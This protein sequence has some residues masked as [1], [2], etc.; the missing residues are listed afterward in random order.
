[1]SE[2]LTQQEIDALLRM[3]QGSGE[4]KA[5]EAITS[6]ESDVLGEVGNIGMGT[7]ATTLSVLINKKV[8]I[9]TPQVDVIKMKDLSKEC[10][11]PCVAVEIN[12]TQGLEGTNLLI[13][14]RHDV[15]VI[16]DLMMGGSGEVD[17]NDDELTD[18]H[19]SAI[20]EVMNQMMGSSSTSLSS[21]LGNQINISPP[22]PTPID[23]ADEKPIGYYE[24]DKPVVL[25]SFKMDIED[26]IHSKIMQ[27]MSID[28][29]KD[30][31]AKL[32]DMTIGSPEPID[33][34]DQQIKEQPKEEEYQEIS[35]NKVE[36]NQEMK[37]KKDNNQK[38]DVV[39]VQ[40]QTFDTQQSTE[41]I[42][43]EK[44]DLIMDIPL[45]VTVVL[46]K[47]KKEVREI[48]QL[49][50]GS[51]IELEKLAGEPVDILVN[52]KQI[53]WGEVVVIDENF[54]VRINDIVSPTKRIEKMGV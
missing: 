29:A 6:E 13:L 16:T 42:S 27:I 50:T 12:Y 35:N 22:M 23:F 37:M 39:P 24:E 32:Y 47:T 44:L 2:L 18:I 20:G 40:F 26:L 48:L 53:A 34:V 38:I 41:V 33:T 9:T 4:D 52:G 25:V 46:G 14:K 5:A 31:V 10:P 19:L 28:F 8:V 15:K 3:S 30:M 11:Y 1:M 54:G 17:A 7:A 21:V 49:G 43:K 51:I 45:Q 36:E